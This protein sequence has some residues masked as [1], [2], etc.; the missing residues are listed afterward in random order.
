M[1]GCT[2]SVVV[3]VAVVLIIIYAPDDFSMSQIGECEK[4]GISI[5]L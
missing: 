1:N 3:I 2:A 5:I 4:I